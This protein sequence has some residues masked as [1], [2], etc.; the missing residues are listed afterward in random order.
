MR[1]MI[2]AKHALMLS[3]LLFAGITAAYAQIPPG[4]QNPTSEPKAEE[5]QPGSE[6][7]ANELQP[8]SEP[9]T[10]ELQPG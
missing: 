8:G 10:E 3:M 2:A 6:P 9:K 5:L 4:V 1:E 7:K